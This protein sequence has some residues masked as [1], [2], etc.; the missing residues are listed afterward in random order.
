MFGVVHLKPLVADSYI[1]NV[2]TVNQLPWKGSYN[3]NWTIGFVALW[4]SGLL[5]GRGY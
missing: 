2:I 1:Y 3:C 4:V 5:H